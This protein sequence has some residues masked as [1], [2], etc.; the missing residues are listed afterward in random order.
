MKHVHTFSTKEVMVPFKCDVHGWMNAY[1]GVLDHPFYAVT[2]ADGS[3]SLK[4]C[5]GDVHRRGVAREARHA[6]TDGHGRGDRDQGC[7]DD[8]QALTC[9]SADAPA[10]VCAAR[11]GLDRR[12]DFAG[13]LVTSTGSGLSVPDWPT[14]YGWSMF[15]FPLSKMVGG[16]RYEHTH[17]LIASTVGFLIVILAAWL[18]RL[19]RARGCAGSVTRARRRHHAGHPRRHHRAV[20]PAGS[21]SIAHAGLAQ[22]VFC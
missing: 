1:V 14:T 18:W 2:G 12:A 8:V 10:P 9:P 6:N 7:R 21:I 4:G 15:T 19:N 16:I 22:L 20:V 11:G 3:F 5:P 17:R 13:G